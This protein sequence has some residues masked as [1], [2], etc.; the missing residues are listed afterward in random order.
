MYK[1]RKK[2]KDKNDEQRRIG[3]NTPIIGVD[4]DRLKERIEW[5]G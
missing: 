3:G 1:R 4:K 2:Q 5:R